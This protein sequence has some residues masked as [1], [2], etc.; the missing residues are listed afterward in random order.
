MT[1]GGRE[2]T[3]KEGTRKGGKEAVAG[4]FSGLVLKGMR[5]ASG[6]E[7]VLFREGRGQRTGKEPKLAW[8][9]GKLLPRSRVGPLPLL[10]VSAESSG[11]LG[12]YLGRSPPY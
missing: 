4:M 5:D 11:H 9:P 10:D 2:E 6:N 12:R 7:P 1:E 8:E 3:E